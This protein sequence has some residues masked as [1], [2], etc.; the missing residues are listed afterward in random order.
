[1]TVLGEEYIKLVAQFAK[2]GPDLLDGYRI[3]AKVYGSRGITPEKLPHASDQEVQQLRQIACQLNG[4]DHIN[5]DHIRKV[6]HHT[7]SRWAA[8]RQ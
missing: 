4:S 3:F 8:A 2:F 7:L 5:G 1:M 6:I